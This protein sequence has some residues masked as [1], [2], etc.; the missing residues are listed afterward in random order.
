MNSNTGDAGA[1]GHRRFLLLTFLVGVA[2]AA[3]LYYSL[4]WGIGVSP[5]SVAYLKSASRFASDF[6]F[7]HLPSHWPPA[8]PL[9]L[10]AMTALVPNILLAA[11]FGQIL[12]FAANTV[13][14][15]LIVRH[16][17]AGAGKFW[18]ALLASVVF[19][20]N[21]AVL[22]LHQYA[23]SE[24]LF[25]LFLFL[26]IAACLWF[27]NGES[28][29]KLVFAALLV[30]CLPVTRYAGLP[31]L[32][33]FAAWIF[34]GQYGGAPRRRIRAWRAVVFIAVASLPLLCWLLLNIL[35]RGESTNRTFAYHPIGRSRFEELFQV[36]RS[37][38][39]VPGPDLLTTLAIATIAIAAFRAL[40]N[41]ASSDRRR[42]LAVGLL[43]AA[44]LYVLFLFLSISFMDAYSPLDQRML[45]PAW[46]MLVM[47]LFIALQAATTLRFTLCA[48]LLSIVPVLLGY[49]MKS[50]DQIVY[51][52]REGLGFQSRDAATSELL[53]VVD[54]A[55]A[56]R[57]IYSNASDYIFLHT[58]RE[59]KPLP[60]IYMAT[61]QERNPQFIYEMAAILEE[62]DKQKA[63]I[64]YFE[65]FEFRQYYPTSNQLRHEFS[66]DSSL[67]TN[68]GTYFDHLSTHQ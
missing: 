1:L 56:N 57:Q 20:C 16:L 61:T 58:G 9:F 5:D 55:Y 33:V 25:I 68:D 23:V 29:F 10:A 26:G 35:K 42:T 51:S 6:Q 14:F 17:I 53:A 62:I 38:F 8:Y 65:G 64:V 47:A 59:V 46:I 3:I 43:I 44:L 11:L 66:L 13:A 39:E 52:S 48:L 24:P 40:A 63:A 49:G 32:P 2:A 22:L 19:A 18:I 31:F 7:K 30:G 28:T 21:P 67:T 45:I 15:S 27:L 36:F 12:L 50:I 54:G 37:W 4:P 34:F 41:L 60:V